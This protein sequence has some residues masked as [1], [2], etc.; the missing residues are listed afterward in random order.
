MGQM[1]T[2]VDG[3]KLR[4][5]QKTSADRQKLREGLLTS[6][7]QY[8]CDGYGICRIGG[9]NNF[10]QCNKCGKPCFSIFGAW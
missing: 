1:K 3:Q 4:F 10:F 2:S 6:K 9:A 7:E 8:H 5:T